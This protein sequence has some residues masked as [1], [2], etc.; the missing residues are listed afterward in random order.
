MLICYFRDHIVA[1][2]ILMIIK[3]LLRKEISLEKIPGYAPPALAVEA[4]D[5]FAIC[6]YLDASCALTMNYVYK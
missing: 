1:S 3:V 6:K 5:L 4:G 2:G